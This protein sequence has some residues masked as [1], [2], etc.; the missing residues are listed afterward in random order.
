[1]R[2][3]YPFIVLILLLCQ[4]L[5]AQ[6]KNMAPQ[7]LGDI[8]AIYNTGLSSMGGAIS[9]RNGDLWV[10]KYDLWH[11]PDTGKTWSK[12]SMPLP[13]ATILSI[14]F[15]DKNKGIVATYDSG[16]YLTQDGGMSWKR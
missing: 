9:F 14:D 1:M 3:I 4:N 15:L 11:S 7:L 6:W 8:Y 12:L 2:R 13:D 16:I 10:G 5:N